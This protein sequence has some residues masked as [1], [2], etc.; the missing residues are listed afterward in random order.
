[1][2]IAIVPASLQNLQRKGV[3][4]PTLQEPT[5]QAEIAVI[6]RSNDASPVLQQFLNLVSLEGS[7]ILKN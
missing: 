3:I 4:Y 7:L 5:P 1:M 2:G 6:S